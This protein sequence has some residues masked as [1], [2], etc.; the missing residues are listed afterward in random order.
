M[1]QESIHAVIGVRNMGMVRLLNLL[2]TIIPVYEGGRVH[3]D[4]HPPH[5]DDEEQQVQVTDS[6]C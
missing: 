3:D 4:L 1:L 6:T 2:I 5:A